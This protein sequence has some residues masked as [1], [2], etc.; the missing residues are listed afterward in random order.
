MVGH[1][2]KVDIKSFIIQGLPVVVSLL[3]TIEK[4]RRAYCLLYALKEH[5]RAIE[6]LQFKQLNS[7]TDCRVLI[8]ELSVLTHH[9]LSVSDFSKFYRLIETFL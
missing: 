6:S 5:V 9:L 2:H 7:I 3:G 1:D 8:L 4:A